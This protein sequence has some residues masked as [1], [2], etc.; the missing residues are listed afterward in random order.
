MGLEKYFST[1]KNIAAAVGLI[2]VLT[3]CAS[4]Y[5]VPRKVAK[6]V[7]EITYRLASLPIEVISLLKNEP[8]LNGCVE[9]LNEKVCRSYLEEDTTIFGKEEYFGVLKIKKDFLENEQYE[10]VLGYWNEDMVTRDWNEDNE[11]EPIRD[12]EK[13][14][15]VVMYAGKSSEDF[16]SPEYGRSNFPYDEFREYFDKPRA[17]IFDTSDNQLK[18]LISKGLINPAQFESFLN[19]LHERIG[20]SLKLADEKLPKSRE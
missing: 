18:N 16:I 7:I 15:S 14:L 11:Y 3:S 5:E 20:I 1:G 17:N 12:E 13:I 8:P 4:I 2:A 10:L 6:E 9:T 19:D